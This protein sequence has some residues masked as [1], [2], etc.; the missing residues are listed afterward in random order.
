MI[1]IAHGEGTDQAKQM[2]FQL[3]SQKAR[4]KEQRWEGCCLVLSEWTN[5]NRTRGREKKTC[6]PGNHKT[7]FSPPLLQHGLILT[8][9]AGVPSAFMWL[10]VLRRAT[11]KRCQWELLWLFELCIRLICCPSQPYPASS[12]SHCSAV[13]SLDGELSTE[14]KSCVN[15]L[16]GFGTLN[17]N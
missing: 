7:R 6:P 8:G 15:P 1:D 5:W 3:W 13:L 12:E 2:D 11:L 9:L 14:H 17:K 10:L 16:V 4:G